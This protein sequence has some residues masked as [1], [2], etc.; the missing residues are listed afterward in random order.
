[1][2]MMGQKILVFNIIYYAITL[3]LVSLGRDDASS[4][5]GYGFFIV[6][7]WVI[8][9]V[10]LMFFLIRK[11]FYPTSFLEK[12]GI[13]TATPVLSIVAVW[14]ILTFKE[15][16]GS[17]RYFNKGDYRYKVRTINYK[18]GSRVK[19][20]EYYRNRIDAISTDGAW[21]PDSTWVYFSEEGDTLR[22]VKYRNGVEYE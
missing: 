14:L 16:V 1:M 2:S 4:S 18:E 12:I 3:L 13:F 17:E 5:L 21:I 15:E 7:F 10:V 6:G 8:S 22:R 19:R 11:S 20:I 9:A